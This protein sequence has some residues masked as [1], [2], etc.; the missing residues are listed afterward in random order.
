MDRS[1]PVFN[2]YLHDRWQY[3][4]QQRHKLQLYEIARKP[5]TSIPPMYKHRK[6]YNAM[7][8]I[9]ASA[10]RKRQIQNERKRQIDKDNQQMF[11][12][13]TDIFQNGAGNVAPLKKPGYSTYS[14][15]Q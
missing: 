5:T 15:S 6:N 4:S 2:R 11:L 9:F 14:G 3:D 13:M 10:S 8:N 12:R 7:K 1:Q